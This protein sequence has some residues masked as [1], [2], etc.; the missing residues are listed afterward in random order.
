MC[1][2][3]FLAARTTIHQNKPA[4]FMY[5]YF[6]VDTIISCSSVSL[7]EFV[8]TVLSTFCSD[9]PLLWYHSAIVFQIIPLL[10]RLLRE[11]EA[12]DLTVQ[13][14]SS[15]SER[16]LARSIRAIFNVKQPTYDGATPSPPV[17][18]NAPASTSSRQ[19][20]RRSPPLARSDFSLN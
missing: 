9:H 3:Y 18:V 2:F 6:H 1:I 19:V 14:A 13:L 20:P 16:I 12:Q 5:R 4:V 15:L 7:G 11:P 10:R 8:T 17:E